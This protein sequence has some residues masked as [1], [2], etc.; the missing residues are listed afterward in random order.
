MLLFSRNFVLYQAFFLRHVSQNRQ[1]HISCELLVCNTLF[2][3]HTFG[4][5]HHPMFDN[6]RREITLQTKTMNGNLWISHRF[7][8]NTNRS[9][10][11]LFKWHAGNFQK[12]LAV[13]P[14]WKTRNRRSTFSVGK[15][16]YYKAIITKD[17]TNF[18]ALRLK[19]N[20]EMSKPFH[21]NLT[22]DNS[23]N[24]RLWKKGWAHR[25]GGKV[26]L[27]MTA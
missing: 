6:P 14:M 20:G 25:S 17:F 19:W 4:K 24:S 13:F 16:H 5:Q 27:F 3:L 8:L 22:T 26:T 1:G 11:N 18:E 15:D 10:S 21:P 12:N 23:Q 2:N 9:S 7:R